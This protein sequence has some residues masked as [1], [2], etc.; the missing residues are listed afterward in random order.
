MIRS[1]LKENIPDIQD[2]LRKNS[3][4]LK[5]LIRNSLAGGDPRSS[6]LSKY[7]HSGMGQEKKVKNVQF[8]R[9]SHYLN[10]EK[11]KFL[12][13]REESKRKSDFRPRHSLKDLLFTGLGGVN[14]VKG[15]K[16]MF[17]GTI[18]SISGLF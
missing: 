18:G 11:F 13:E 3:S 5:H 9:D 12:R 4:M 16:S 2:I 8:K 1:D 14:S 10:R 7:G 6:R 15:K 17:G